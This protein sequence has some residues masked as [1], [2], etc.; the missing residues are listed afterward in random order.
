MNGQKFYWDSK[1]NIFYLVSF[2]EERYFEINEDSPF[3]KLCMHLYCGVWDGIV[4]KDIERNY[5]KCTKIEQIDGSE[6]L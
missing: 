6:S 1:T 3:H 5:K 2:G 4:K